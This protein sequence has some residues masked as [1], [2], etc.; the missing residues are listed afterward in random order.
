MQKL[1]SEPKT[2]LVFEE[3]GELLGMLSELLREAGVNSLLAD[4]AQAAL[5]LMSAHSPDL[6]VV[7]SKVSELSLS[8]FLRE[9]R[10]FHSVSD[11][12]PSILILADFTDSSHFPLGKLWGG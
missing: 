6:I 1:G 3:D 4:R 5:A 7:S 12:M 2:A 8:E 10:K 9:M 11:S